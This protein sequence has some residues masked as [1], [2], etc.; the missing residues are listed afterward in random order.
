MPGQQTPLETMFLLFK[1]SFGL[2]HRAVAKMILSDRPLTNGRPTAQMAQDT[3]WLSRTIV[4]SQPGSL[5]DRYFVDWSHASKQLLHAL[6][7]KGYSN[8]EIYTAISST[9][10]A[11]ARA[12]SHYGYNGHLYQNAISRLIRRQPDKDNRALVSIA[13]FVSTAC[14]CNPARAITYATNHFSFVN[15]VESLTLPSRIFSSQIDSK[16]LVPH[17]NLGLLRVNDTI[18]LG[19]PYIIKPSTIGSVIG[20]LALEDG[21]ITDVG[22]DVSARHLRIYLDNESWW[23]QDL[24]STNGTHLLGIEANEEVDISSGSPV[25]IHPGDFLRLGLS[26]TFAVAA[27]ASNKSNQ[28]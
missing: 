24:G 22:P 5:E 15:D 17:P 10:A 23:A 12:L 11:M 16:K 18:I 8:D 6:L 7:K 21:A 9:T 28:R 13:L 26:T 2:S 4:H 19:G 27:V 1:A 14:W 3:S 25:Q 20:A